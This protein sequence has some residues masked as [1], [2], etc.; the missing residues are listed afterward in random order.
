MGKLQTLLILIMIIFLVTACGMQEP[1][2]TPS[3]VKIDLMSYT[4]ESLG[5]SSLV[6]SNW[7]P[8]WPYGMFVREMPQSD[9][10]FLMFNVIPGAAMEQLM[11]VIIASTGLQESPESI[12]NKETEN[13]NWTLYSFEIQQGVMLAYNPGYGTL[14]LDIAMAESDGKVFV[15]AAG[16]PVNERDSLYEQVFL[17]ALDALKTYE[18]VESADLPEIVLPERDYWPTKEWRISTPVE[19]GMDGDKLDEMAAYIKE[20]NIPIKNA[21]IVRHG[22]IVLDEN[23]QGSQTKDNLKSVTKSLTSALVGIAIDQ[24][25]IRGVDQSV[26]SLFPNRKIA[27]LDEYKQSMTVEDLLTMRAGL[28][29]PAGPCWWLDGAECADYTTQIML[30][31]ED[32]LQF[33]L[34][35]PM[36]DEPGT[37]F[38]Y[39]SGASH[40]LSTMI[41]ETTGMS[42]FD[43]AIEN[44]FKPLGIQ[45]V[46]WQTDG[47]GLTM[48][49]SDI[50]MYPH[51]MAKIGY[52][53]LNEGQWD[54]EQVISAEWVRDSQKP[55]TT[56]TPDNIQPNYGYQWWVN[57]ELGFYNAAGAGGNYIIVLPEEDM[58]VVFTS[59]LHGVL[60]QDKWWS[61]TPEELFRVYILPAAK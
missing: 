60:G 13:F 43:F 10:T 24:G 19:Q 45:K 58:V 46:S 37:T 30:E 39:I 56:T 26:V 48:G 42:A 12:G 8:F 55:H 44:L 3:P 34:D 17:P 32:S 7:A 18:R 1:A 35:Q 11:A 47:E 27:N 22:Y 57:P 23:F 36:T 15:I 51:D 52:L 38:V 41:S 31:D 4:S 16:T 49:W 61:G 29:W 33:I 50:A 59:E 6:P 5:I 54:G 9:P 40:L 20:N 25:Y 28:D 21:I 2:Q 14:K 53:F